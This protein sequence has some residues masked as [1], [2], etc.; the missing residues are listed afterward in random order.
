MSNLVAAVEKGNRRIINAAIAGLAHFSLGRSYR[1]LLSTANN[2]FNFYEL[3]ISSVASRSNQNNQGIDS[4]KGLTTAEVK[5]GHEVPATTRY[6]AA[7][8]I[9]KLISDKDL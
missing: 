7:V 6:A 8:I 4:G 1:V 2:L 3:L 9:H 5:Q